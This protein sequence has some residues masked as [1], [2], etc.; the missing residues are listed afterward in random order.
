MRGE[1]SHSDSGKRADRDVLSSSG[2]DL[3]NRQWAAARA[4]QRGDASRASIAD[5]VRARG[6]PGADRA[7]LPYRVT[8]AGTLL[9]SGATRSRVAGGGL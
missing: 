2:R 1:F 7:A 6:P 3:V 9:D 4:W 8:V 5:S